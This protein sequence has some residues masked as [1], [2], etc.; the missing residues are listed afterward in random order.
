MLA[1]GRCMYPWSLIHSDLGLIYD[2][3]KTLP[4]NNLYTSSNYA[5]YEFMISKIGV[6]IDKQRMNHDE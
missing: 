2:A 5:K 1:L 3:I 6:G 4:C